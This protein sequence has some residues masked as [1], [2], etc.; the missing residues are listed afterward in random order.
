MG[1]RLN[2][3]TKSLTDFRGHL[4][5]LGPVCLRVSLRELEGHVTRGPSQLQLPG[6]DFFFSGWFSAQQLASL[7]GNL[8]ASAA[9][10]LFSL[11]VVSLGAKPPLQPAARVASAS[12]LAGKLGF[13]FRWG[14]SPAQ[15]GA[16]PAAARLLPAASLL[17]LSPFPLPLDGNSASH[18]L[19]MFGHS[20][21]QRLQPAAPGFWVGLSRVRHPEVGWTFAGKGGG[22]LLPPSAD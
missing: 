13:F 19:G 11:T 18:F 3:T 21:S 7:S 16:E 12:S 1:S 22:S 14:W 8:P 17:F 15:E 9:Q 2:S 20:R 10:P 6:G 5:S 4:R